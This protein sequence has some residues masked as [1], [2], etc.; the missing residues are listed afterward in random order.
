[1]DYFTW[2]DIKPP[3][4]SRREF[5]LLMHYIDNYFLDDHKDKIAKRFLNDKQQWYLSNSS[6]ASDK[7]CEVLSN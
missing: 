5:K 2:N 7:I 3:K 6:L 4:M 1:M